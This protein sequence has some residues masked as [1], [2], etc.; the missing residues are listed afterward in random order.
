MLPKTTDRVANATADEINERIRRDIL[1]SVAGCAADGEGAIQRRLDELDAEWDTER[2]LEA[3]AS[4]LVLAGLGLGTWVDRRFHLLPTI[5]AGFLLQHALQG[6][7]PPL[8]VLRRLGVRTQSEIEMER[9][10]LKAL[11]GDFRETEKI[12]GE[13]GAQVREAMQAVQR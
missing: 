13:A 2:M 7:C 8:P 1:H 10:A 3:N 9:Y 12:T 11:R 4:A 5:V 6:W